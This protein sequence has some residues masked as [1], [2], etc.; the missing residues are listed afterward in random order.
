MCKI[1]KILSGRTGTWPRDQAHHGERGNGPGEA[2][3]HARLQ[4][5]EPDQS[6]GRGNS[7]ATCV[8]SGNWYVTNYYNNYLFLQQICTCLTDSYTPTP[9]F[10]RQIRIYV[11]NKL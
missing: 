7:D 1:G 6:S 10:L 8:D 4:Q 3:R 11:Y 9:Y 2:G 5:V